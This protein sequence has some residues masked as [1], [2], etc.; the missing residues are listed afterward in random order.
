MTY[1][2]AAELSVF[3]AK[4]IHPNTLWPVI[5][6]NIN[7]F[8]GSTFNPEESGTWITKTSHGS[9]PV[10]RALAER[11]NQVLL[12]IKSYDMVHAQGFLAKVFSILSEHKVSVDLVTTSEVSIAL[13]L[14]HIGSQSIGNTLLTSSLMDDLHG[15]GDVDIK[16][17]NNLSLIAV[18]G[19][20]IH[21]TKNIS[22]RVFSEL[23]DY[24]IRLF[25]HGASGH[26]MCLLVDKCDSQNIIQKLYNQFFTSG[27]L[28]I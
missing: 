19:N 4:I 18:V 22:N 26:N 14:D 21:L 3:G 5:R 28:F 27:G 23:T 24:N 9:L 11:K 6:N 13:T 8:I 15:I 17:D 16:V 25:S 12:T 20:D 2:E 10:I 1:N 7:I